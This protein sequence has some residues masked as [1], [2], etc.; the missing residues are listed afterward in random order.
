MKYFE[1]IVFGIFASLGALT[2][3]IIFLYILP[4]PFPSDLPIESLVGIFYFLISTAII[5][6]SFKFWA[7]ALRKEEIKNIRSLIFKVI[8]V[9]LGFFL[10]ET[11]L[12]LW[13]SGFN[14]AFFPL[15]DIAEIFLLHI[16]TLGLG[17]AM[18]AIFR[19]KLIVIPTIAVMAAAHLAFNAMVNFEINNFIIVSYLAFLFIL[20]IFLYFLA[21]RKI[22][23]Y[24]S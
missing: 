5:E 19:N 10:T 24:L 17:G 8:F 13:K 14:F 7:L 23:A 18:L 6:E 15:K 3:E 1:F 16:F 20:N 4:N 11:T 9:G 21:A 22:K 2:A 12:N